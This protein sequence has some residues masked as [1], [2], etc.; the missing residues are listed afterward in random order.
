VSNQWPNTDDVYARSE[1]SRDR[2]R[3]L[4]VAEKAGGNFCREESIAKLADS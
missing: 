3:Q 2:E 1:A 4:E